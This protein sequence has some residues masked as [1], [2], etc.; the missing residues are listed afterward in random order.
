MMNDAAANDTIAAVSTPLGEGGIGIVR[1]SG[2]RAVEIAGA[3][4]RARSGES[5]SSLPSRRARLGHI[6]DGDEVLDEVLLTVMRAPATYTREDVVEISGHGGAV[7]LQ[8]VL[9]LVLRCGARLAEPGEFTRR[10]FLSGRIDLAQAEAVVDLVRGRTEEAARAALRQ[11]GGELSAE[12]ERIH[13]DLFDL[14]VRVEADIDFP[15]E[16]LDALPAVELEARATAVRAGIDRLLSTSRRGMMLRDGIKAVIV[17]RPNVGKSSLMNGLLRRD[18][19]IVTPVPGTTRD[20]VSETVNIQGI[21]VVLYDTAGIRDPRDE[22]EEQGVRLSRRHLE[23]AD[24]VL[25]VL[26]RSEP[27]DGEDRA[28]ASL[29]AERAVVVALNKSDLHARLTADDASF[30]APG[31]PFVDVS[32]TEGTGIERLEGAIVQAVQGKRLDGTE[33]AVVTRARHRDALVR[34]GEALERAM[35]AARE[36]LAPEFVS[37]D[38]REALDALGEITGRTAPEEIL[39][40]IFSDFCIGK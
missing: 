11:L 15:E 31:A 1:L 7:A 27:L 33:G 13:E 2:P 17:G 16:D 26:D 40:R 30:L 25:L 19:V 6:V 29:S 22:V 35:K 8:A 3:V 4:F 32:A 12:V 39:D 21:P 14:L 10:A 37:V 20:A 5:A 18:R 38:L 34:A 9:E 28:I 23:E 24:L 36:G